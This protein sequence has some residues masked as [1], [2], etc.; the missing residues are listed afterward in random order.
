MTLLNRVDG[1]RATDT[2]T[3]ILYTPAYWETDS[4]TLSLAIRANR[5]YAERLDALESTIEGDVDCEFAHRSVFKVGLDE[6][7][8]ETLNRVRQRMFEYCERSDLLF[9]DETGSVSG[10][11]VARWLRRFARQSVESATAT[12]HGSTVGC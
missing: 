2:G 9:N 12:M 10:E 5:H 11:N 4:T 3:G 7:D 6:D 1:G 8:R